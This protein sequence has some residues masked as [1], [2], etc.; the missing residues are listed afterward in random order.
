M[1]FRVKGAGVV[2]KGFG[3]RVQGLGF[4]G[5]SDVCEASPTLFVGCRVT[6]LSSVSEAMS[7]HAAFIIMDCVA[8][9]LATTCFLWVRN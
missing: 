1:E 5:Y 7:V 6:I 2:D 9:T 8:F 4:R 3:C